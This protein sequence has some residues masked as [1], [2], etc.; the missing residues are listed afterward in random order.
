MI[1]A[2]TV[3]PTELLCQSKGFV[4]MCVLFTGQYSTFLACTLMQLLHT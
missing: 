3:D 1:S 2:Y 4:R